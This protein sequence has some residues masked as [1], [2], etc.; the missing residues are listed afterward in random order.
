VHA[1]IDSRSAWSLLSPCSSLADYR[2]AL[3]AL[4]TLNE[5]QF[6][7]AT[8]HLVQRSI[9]NGGETFDGRLKVLAVRLLAREFRQEESQV[10][11]A[12]LNDL[13]AYYQ[14]HLDD[15]QKLIHVGESKPDASACRLINILSSSKLDRQI[16][17]GA[18][19]LRRR[20]YTT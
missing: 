4:V 7:E 12:S 5:E 11:R 19:L 2:P 9:M 15:A 18:K 13:R 17:H 10:V 6:I 16:S 3:Q 14:K 1:Q 20:R 8:R